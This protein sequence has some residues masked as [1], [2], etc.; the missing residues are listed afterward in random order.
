MSGLALSSLRAER[1]EALKSLMDRAVELMESYPPDFCHKPISLP[2]DQKALNDPPG[3]MRDW[4]NGLQNIFVECSLIISTSMHELEQNFRNSI[5]QRVRLPNCQ[6]VMRHLLSAI[7]K[8]TREEPVTHMHFTNAVPPEPYV[9][10]ILAQ[11]LAIAV[12]PREENLVDDALPYFQ[13]I[14]V[15]LGRQAV[16]WLAAKD[17][18]GRRKLNPDKA[19]R[20]RWYELH[21]LKSQIQVEDELQA[22]DLIA[23]YTSKIVVGAAWTMASLMAFMDPRVFYVEGNPH[24]SSV[25][26]GDISIS[27]SRHTHIYAEFSPISMINVVKVLKVALD[28]LPV[29]ASDMMWIGASFPRLLGHTATFSTVVAS[30]P[31]PFEVFLSHRGKDAKQIL[32]NAVF[33]SPNRHKIFLDCLVLGTGLINRHFVFRSLVRSRRILIVETDNFWLSEWCQKEAWL[34]QVLSDLNISSTVRTNSAHDIEACIGHLIDHDAA[35]PAIP[36]ARQAS[37]QSP[38]GFDQDKWDRSP[39]GSG[40]TFRILK[41]TD[42][43]F[44]VPNLHSAKEKGLDVKHIINFREWLE[45]QGATDEYD[46]RTISSQIFALLKAILPHIFQF[47]TSKTGNI[48][49]KFYIDYFDLVAAAMQL[50]VG[51]LCS[52]APYYSKKKSRRSFDTI[53]RVSYDICMNIDEC[54]AFDTASAAFY[55]SLAAC[56]IS[57]ELSPNDKCVIDVVRMM[58]RPPFLLREDTVLLDARGGTRRNA[59]DC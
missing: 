48:E 4:P 2:D 1:A 19:S 38:P 14:S 32:M 29:S 37:I 58:I 28:G 16:G 56:V 7:T 15:L 26:Y 3:I 17:S 24:V 55:F 12:G 47:H 20:E 50:S 40:I 45:V 25:R 44:R 31:E 11:E 51:A 41:D 57:L 9:E 59:T 13:T 49:A 46:A 53:A 27:M 33:S 54:G 36:T 10:E 42:L 43:W 6:K 39:Y 18:D 34:A 5:P 22:L 52:R 23:P 21:T 30:D 35:E 8:A